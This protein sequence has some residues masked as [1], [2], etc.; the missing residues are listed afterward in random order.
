MT[1]WLAGTFDPRGRTD[2]ARLAAALDPHAATLAEAGPLR[3]AYSGAAS[4]A[5]APLCLLDGYV[6]NAS[7]LSEAL[8][9]PD[10]GP[11][12]QL[13]AAGWRR[14]GAEL[15][16][17]LRGDFALLLWD[18]ARGEGL[19]ARDQIGVRS[20]FLHDGYEGL[21]FASEVRQLLALLPQRPMPDPVSV[22]HW[23]TMSNRPGSA[24]LYAGVRRLNPGAALLLDR[25]GTREVTY[26]TPRFVEPLNESEPQLAQR[27][28]ASLNRAVSLRLSPE[29]LTGVLMS[30]GL[31]SAAV[32]AVATTQ[33]PGRVTGQSAVFPARVAGR[34]GATA[35]QLGGLLGAAA[36]ACGSGSRR[37]CNARW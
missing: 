3:V 24:T 36:A 4:D 35:A 8:G 12:E 10:G 13:L 25:H 1:R 17:R 16:P 19:L 20:M 21:C 15:L 26:W 5:R 27:V 23:I 2:S 37:R 14:W 18:D 30:G 28:H 11:H 9:F 6:D 22:A 29:K 7:E 32:A 31:D 34:L 33:A